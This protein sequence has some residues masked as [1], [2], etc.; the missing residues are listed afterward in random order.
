M[1]PLR[2]GLAVAAGLALGA[3]PFL[4]YVHVGHSALPHTDHAPRHGGTLLMVSDYH[5]ELLRR[6]G[7]IEVFVSDATRRPVAVSAG[8]ASF[9]GGEAV[10]LSADNQRWVAPDA[11]MRPA[12]EITVLLPDG[13]RL[14]AVFDDTPEPPGV[15]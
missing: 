12:V 2:I 11:P 3:L 10:P 5:I 14:A 13:A 6:G 9:G 7:R 1:T 4:R 15:P 8:W